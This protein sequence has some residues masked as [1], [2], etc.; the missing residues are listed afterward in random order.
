[1][2]DAPAGVSAAVLS[3]LEAWICRALMPAAGR[4]LPGFTGKALVRC[5]LQGLCCVVQGPLVPEQDWTQAWADIGGTFWL[6]R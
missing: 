4:Q 5:S 3:L 1:M 2:L 6:S